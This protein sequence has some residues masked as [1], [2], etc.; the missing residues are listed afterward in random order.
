M[1]YIK[2]L[3]LKFLTDP[4]RFQKKTLLQNQKI[5]SDTFSK[6]KLNRSVKVFKNKVK[7]RSNNGY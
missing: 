5:Y 2:N 3:K 1:N 7:I 6:E 4:L